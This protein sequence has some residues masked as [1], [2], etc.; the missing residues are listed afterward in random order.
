MDIVK[1]EDQEE[2]LQNLCLTPW[3]EEEMKSINKGIR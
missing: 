2:F 1:N 3:E